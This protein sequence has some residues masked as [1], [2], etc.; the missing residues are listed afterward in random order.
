LPP[1]I[2]TIKP[3][4]YTFKIKEVVE[5]RGAILEFKDQH[6]AISGN[7]LSSIEED[8]LGEDQLRKFINNGVIARYNN[9]LRSQPAEKLVEDFLGTFTVGPDQISDAEDLAEL[10]KLEGGSEVT[11][12]G[13]GKEKVKEKYQESVGRQ[14]EKLRAMMQ[15]WERA[16][17]VAK[18]FMKVTEADGAQ[19]ARVVAS[20]FPQSVMGVPSFAGIIN[21]SPV[22]YMVLHH[23]MS[24][25]MPLSGGGKSMPWVHFAW[26]DFQKMALKDP[27]VRGG[28]EKLVRYKR[29]DR[30]P[31]MS[32]SDGEISALLS[33]Q[34]VSAVSK[35]FQRL[36]DN[37]SKA[38]TASKDA[39]E[40]KKFFER[41]KVFQS[42]IQPQLRAAVE[43]YL[44]ENDLSLDRPEDVAKVEKFKDKYIQKAVNRMSRSAGQDTLIHQLMVRMSAI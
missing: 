20:Q 14:R 22:V 19:I 30:A 4:M 16:P 25:H 41:R 15:R 23:I 42:Y 13:R 31:D 32:V 28:M 37:I 26:E 29:K 35:Y 7:A 6:E 12:K 21:T 39:P 11:S 34:G 3:G 36:R 1:E 8:G 24:P 38:I 43:Q 10:I 40:L 18:H 17:E 27:L 5:G 2:Q 33:G 44:K 9:F